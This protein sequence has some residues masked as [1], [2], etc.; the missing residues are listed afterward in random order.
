M[1]II[2]TFIGDNRSLV[3]LVVINASLGKEDHVQCPKNFDDNKV[4]KKN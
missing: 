4:L 2:K 1:F 3:G